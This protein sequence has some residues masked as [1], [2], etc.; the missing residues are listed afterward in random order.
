MSAKRLL[1]VST[2]PQMLQA[3]L[4]PFADH[5]RAQ[6]W[7]VDAMAAD[8]QKFPALIQHFDQTWQVPF[9][10]NPLFWRNLTTVPRAIRKIV[11]EQQYDIVHVH[12]PVAAFVVRYALRNLKSNR[13]KVIYTAHG[14][15]FHSG[16]HPIKNAMF[17]LLEKLAGRWTDSLIVINRED[18]AAAKR[19]HFLPRKLIQY[20][21]GIGVDLENYS[22]TKVSTEAMA[23]IRHQLNI[24]DAAPIFL[25]VAEFTPQKNQALTL[26]AFAALTDTRAQLIF[27][28]V[29]ATLER[30]QQLAKQLGVAERVHFLGF[31]KD[32]PTL[33]CMARAVL[34]V[35]DR[36]GLSRSIMEAMSLE[37][38]VIG[39][40]IRGIRDL[41]QDGAGMLIPTRNCAALTQAMQ[42]VLLKPE[43]ASEMGQVGRKQ[44]MQYNLPNIISMHEALYAQ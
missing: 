44:V 34:L 20:M 37:T 35:S 32:I 22:K 3:C 4:L 11:T 15:H 27:A 1:I 40:N 26:R 28:G 12:T 6:G 24:A 38:A 14:F 2:V 7:R 23:V 21:P 39:T 19:F 17:F 8:M 25:Q 41:L 36:E 43:L 9:S 30:T 5:F 31:R 18:E 42:S 10:R 33:I 13:P 29:G 16:G